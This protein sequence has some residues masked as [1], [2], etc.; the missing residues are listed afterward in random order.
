MIKTDHVNAK[1]AHHNLKIKL[2][3]DTITTTSTLPI[4]T[5]FQFVFWECNGRP[6]R[7]LTNYFFILRKLST[8]VLGV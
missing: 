1:I 5:Y 3:M 2:N 4:I 8:M 6:F 7:L